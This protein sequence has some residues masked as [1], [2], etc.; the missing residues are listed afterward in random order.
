M[1]KNNNNEIIRLNGTTVGAVVFGFNRNSLD[2][3]PG[4]KNYSDFII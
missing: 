2:F 1:K 3:P 4:K